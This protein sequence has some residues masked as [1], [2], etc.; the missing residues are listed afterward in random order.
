MYCQTASITLAA[1]SAVGIAAAQTPSG[2]GPLTLTAT[3]VVLDAARRV[4]A[5]SSNVADNGKTVTLVGS[6]RTNTQI[7]E[8]LT[9]NSTTAPY[10]V[11][12]FKKVASATVSAATTGTVS[13]GTSG[14]GSTGWIP[15]NLMVWQFNVGIAV[16]LGGATANYTVEMTMDDP[17]RAAFEERPG[18]SGDV[19]ATAN[20]AW[21]SPVTFTAITNQ[22]SDNI[23]SITTP[24]R[25]VRLTIN[26]GAAT[27]GPRITVLQ[28]GRF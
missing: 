14:I 18:G 15:L 27:A 22:T 4:L 11:Q 5:T 28:I 2:A 24:V 26:S 13:L 16:N 12:D 10:T 1:S 25:A 9:L 23:T 8:V 7:S 6:D 17:N 21:A 20:T 19:A 3:P